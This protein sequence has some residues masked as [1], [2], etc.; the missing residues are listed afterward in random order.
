MAAYFDVLPYWNKNDSFDPYDSR[1]AK[2]SLSR[3]LTRFIH[4][5]NQ[6]KGFWG[7]IWGDGI[8]RFVESSMND[9]IKLITYIHN[10]LRDG[11]KIRPKLSEDLLLSISTLFIKT[12]RGVEYKEMKNL[13]RYNFFYVEPIK[14]SMG[15]G[16]KLKTIN[17]TP[18]L[19]D[20]CYHCMRLAAGRCQQCNNLLCD[21][22]GCRGQHM[23]LLS[24]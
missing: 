5:Y 24:L 14:C 17:P 11:N 12:P 15:P 20:K 23:C 4:E 21:Q 10:I 16:I 8:V 9:P 2:T 22:Y 3:I 13:R 1:E 19:R 6:K 18:N 7:L